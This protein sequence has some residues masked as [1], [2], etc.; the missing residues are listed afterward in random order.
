MALTLILTHTNITT[1]FCN[2]FEGVNGIPQ[3]YSHVTWC[4]YCVKSINLSLTKKQKQTEMVIPMSQS[5]I[6]EINRV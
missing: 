4:Y 3:S 2:V 1:F 6:I 5:Y